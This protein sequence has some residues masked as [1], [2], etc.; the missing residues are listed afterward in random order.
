MNSN[1]NDAIA[2]IN[3]NADNKEKPFISNIEEKLESETSRK[4][5]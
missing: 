4:I 3:E 2:R 5:S 1:L